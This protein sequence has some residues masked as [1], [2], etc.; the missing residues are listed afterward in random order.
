MRVY[1]FASWTRTGGGWNSVGAEVH[2]RGE[3]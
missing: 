2:S 1:S 3:S